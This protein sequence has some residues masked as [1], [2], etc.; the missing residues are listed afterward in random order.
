MGKK[1]PFSLHKS[2]KAGFFFFFLYKKKSTQAPFPPS[3]DLVVLL[4]API[5]REDQGKFFLP[6]SRCQRA[7]PDASSATAF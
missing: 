3:D 2:M 1:L 5:P 6:S 4:D 7:R